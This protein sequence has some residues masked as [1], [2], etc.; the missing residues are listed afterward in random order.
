MNRINDLLKR[1]SLRLSHI[2]TSIS[3]QKWGNGWELASSGQEDRNNGAIAAGEIIQHR[4][5]LNILPRANATLAHEHR[6]RFASFE[7]R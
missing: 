5:D 3:A 4:L 7:I 2:N 6:C 1:I